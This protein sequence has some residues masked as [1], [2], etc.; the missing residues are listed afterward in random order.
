MIQA[1]GLFLLPETHAPTLLRRRARRLRKESGDESLHTEFEKDKTPAK[2]LKPALVR[3]FR[4]LGT[5]PIVQVI[6]VYMAYL[7]GVFYL[8]LSTF[9]DVWEGV[10]GENFGV[11]GL[12]YIS[13]AGGYLLGAQVTVAV[14]DKVYRRLK[15]KNHDIG[16]PEF[17]IPLMFPGSILMP[18]GLFWYGWS[19]RSNVH[20]IVPNIGIFVFASG[21]IVCSQC[22]QT[23]IIDSY[24]TFAASGLAAAVVLRSLAGFGFPLFA[25]YMYNSL[26]YDGVTASWDSRRLPLEFPHHSCSGYLERS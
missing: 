3:P 19:A 11:G 26:G 16:R 14:N 15:H 20:W 10:Y 12:N 21:A 9:P 2:L 8:I 4:L 17:R 5:Q 23:Y 7:F 1:I 22:M 18:I 13:L 25:P 24:A 6:A